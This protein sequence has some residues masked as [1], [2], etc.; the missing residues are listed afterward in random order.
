EEATQSFEAELVHQHA[1]I[2]FLKRVTPLLLEQV[3]A[4]AVSASDSG[5]DADVGLDSVAEEDDEI[6]VNNQGVG[7]LLR[8]P[9]GLA[10]GDGR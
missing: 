2:A 10:I 6:T 7:P 1:T 5:M 4:A 3:E 9:P 8:S